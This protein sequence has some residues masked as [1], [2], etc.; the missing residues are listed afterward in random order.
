MKLADTNYD[1]SETG[2]CARLD[3]DKWNEREFVWKDR[4]FLKDHIRAVWHVPLNMGTV[5]ARD[6]KAIEEAAAY[7][8]DPLWLSDEVSPWGADVYV[9]V[10]HAVP[11]TETVALSGRFLTKVFEGP[12]RDIGKWLK[13]MDAYVHAKGLETKRHLFYYATCP[14]CAKHFGTNHVVLFAEVASGDKSSAG[15]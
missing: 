13:T 9:A 11:D 1:N 3:V 7:P 14:K 6:Q 8:E 10:N 15:R 12:Y 2:C 4:L 5:M